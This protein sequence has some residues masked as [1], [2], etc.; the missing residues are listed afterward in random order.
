MGRLRKVLQEQQMNEPS[1]DGMKQFNVKVIEPDGR[2]WIGYVVARTSDAAI[3]KFKEEYG[4][5]ASEKS[6]IIV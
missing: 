2:S 6:Y 1:A 3:N 4:V 5:H